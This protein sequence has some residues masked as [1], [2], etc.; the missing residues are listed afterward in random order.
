MDFMDAAVIPGNQ[1][2]PGKQFRE[3]R[4]KEGKKK[5][6]KLVSIHHS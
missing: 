6:G 5:R 3:R 4:E 1:T 2:V